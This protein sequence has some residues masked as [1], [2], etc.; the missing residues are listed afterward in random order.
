MEVHPLIHTAH[1]LP[2]SGR[3]ITETSKALREQLSAL[4]DY[5]SAR[6]GAVEKLAPKAS[7]SRVLGG[8]ALSSTLILDDLAI[9]GNLLVA[10]LRKG[11]C[12]GGCD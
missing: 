2:S 9:P 4:P 1:P 12:A 3:H 10:A 6:A 11:H 7:A 8:S 5:F